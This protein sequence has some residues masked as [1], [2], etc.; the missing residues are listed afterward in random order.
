MGHQETGLQIR[1]DDFIPVPLRD[2]RN[3]LR[4]GDTGVVHQDRQRPQ[5]GVGDLDEELNIL[6]TAHV[7]LNGQGSAAEFA[8]RGRGLLGFRCAVQIVHRHIGSGPRE[9]YRYGPPDTPAGAGYQRHSSCKIGHVRHGSTNAQG[10][11]G[12]DARASQQGSPPVLHWGVP[13]TR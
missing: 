4:A 11:A 1:I 7:R 6:G 9:R 2:F 10:L 3:G 8:N 12:T 5:F 13:N